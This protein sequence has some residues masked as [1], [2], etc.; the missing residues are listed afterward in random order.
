[1]APNLMNIENL[2]KNDQV[3]QK[4]SSVCI[5]TEIDKLKTGKVSFR[6]EASKRAER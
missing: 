1:M 4:S 2:A 3:S 5:I 6:E